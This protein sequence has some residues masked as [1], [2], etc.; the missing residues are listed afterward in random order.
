MLTVAIQAGGQ[1]RR[2]G[3]DKGLVLLN[4]RPL[5]RHLLDRVAD[6]G[7]EVLITTNDSEGYAFLGVKLTSD[8]TPGAGALSGLRTALKAAHGDKVL[9]LACD[10][11]FVSRPLLTYMIGLAPQADVI[12]PRPAGEYEPMH[13]IYDKGCLSAIEASLEAGD[14]RMISFFPAVNVLP[15]EDD[16]LQRLDPDHR[17]FFNVNTPAD[18]VHAERL[19]SEA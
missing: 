19:L 18:L 7:D 2:M 17:S 6:L 16:V 4:G 3:R 9:V 5:V 8:E 11:P 14:M 10:M 13:A 15:V 12:V 1:S